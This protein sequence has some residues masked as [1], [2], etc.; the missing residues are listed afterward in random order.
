MRL[1]G[2]PKLLGWFGCSSQIFRIQKCMQ[3]G[4]QFVIQ[5]GMQVCGESTHS[6]FLFFSPA[7]KPDRT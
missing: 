3:F 4:M 6:L 2:I 7:Q 1:K 5:F